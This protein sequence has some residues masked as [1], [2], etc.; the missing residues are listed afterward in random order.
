MCLENISE[1]FSISNATGLH[2]YV[3]D[4]S[5]HYKTIANYKIH[6]IHRY[7]MKK[8][9]LYKMFRVVKKILATIFLVSSVSSLKCVL[10]KNQECKSRK[11]ITNNEYMLYPFSIKVSKCSGNCNI[12]SNPYSRVCVPSVVKNIT[13]K[14]FDLMSWKNKNKTNKMA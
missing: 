7:L 10:M 11:V 3:Y 8:S 6:D 4:F 5:V 9:I 2:E 13:A 14:M 1:D 12:I